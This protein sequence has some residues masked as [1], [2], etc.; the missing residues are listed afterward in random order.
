MSGQAEE[1]GWVN[2][3]LWP[4]TAAAE[5]SHGPD[6]LHFQLNNLFILLYLRNYAGA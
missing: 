3:H 1:N 4:A 2:S 5:L 6:I